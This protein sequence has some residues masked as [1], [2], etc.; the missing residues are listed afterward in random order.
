MKNSFKA[1]TSLTRT[2]RIGIVALLGVLVLLVIVRAT[3]SMW[4][5]PPI[6]TA[7][8]E[9]LTKAWETYKNA[10]AVQVKKTTADIQPLP[11]VINI[12]TADSATLIRLKGLGE[13]NVSRILYYR[14]E[15]GR[16]TDVEQI[17]AICHMPAAT[18]RELKKHISVSATE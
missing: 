10:H 16:F 3:M 8:Q 2:E 11:D 4:V 6:D 5:K 9:K 18:F 12:N 15:Y 14:R 17:H 7:Q 1:Y 13:V